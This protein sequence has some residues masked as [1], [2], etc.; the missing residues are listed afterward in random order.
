MRINQS[1]V[2]PTL[3]HTPENP[4]TGS[5]T[6]LVNLSLSDSDI[7]RVGAYAIYHSGEKVRVIARQ[8]IRAKIRMTSWDACQQYRS[9]SRKGPK[10]IHWGSTNNP[11]PFSLYFNWHLKN[12]FH[13]ISSA[14]PNQG[15]KGSKNYAQ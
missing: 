14:A 7:D 5:L 8:R 6:P 1:S 15:P 2:L 11:S 10:R 13:Q 3:P 9:L 12:A 4:P